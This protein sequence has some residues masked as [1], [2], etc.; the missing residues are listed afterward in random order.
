[1]DNI[2]VYAVEPPPKEYDARYLYNQLQLLHKR[3]ESAIVP[4][5]ILAKQYQ[6]PGRLMEGMVV[7]ADGT[8]WNP[9]GGAGLYQYLSSAWVKL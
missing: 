8:S 5:V 7:N 3:L 6:E 9:G 4:W 1:M 2:L